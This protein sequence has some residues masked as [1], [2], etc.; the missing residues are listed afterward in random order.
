MIRWLSFDPTVRRNVRWVAILV[1]ALVVV[2]VGWLLFSVSRPGFHWINEDHYIDYQAGALLKGGHWHWTIAAVAYDFGHSNGWVLPPVY[3]VFLSMFASGEHVAE[4]PAAIAQ[5]IISSLTPLAVFWMAVRLHGPRAGLLAAALAASGQL[6]APVNAFVQE[7]IYVPLLI[8]SLAA[9]IHAIDLDS[10]P[11][12]WFAAGVLMAVTT[13]TRALTLY[14][15]P[16]AILWGWWFAADRRHA[17]AQWRAYGTG[18]LALVLP[19]IIYV[20]IATGELVLIDNHGGTLQLVDL[21]PGVA[22]PTDLVSS[23]RAVLGPLLQA[24]GAFVADFLSYVSIQFRAN[25]GTWLAS[26]GD[27]PTPALALVQKIGAHLS[28]DLPWTIAA[29]LGPIGFAF[30][31][32][33]RAAQLMVLWVIVAIGLTSL[34]HYAGPRYRVPFESTLAVA[35]CV[36]VAGPRIAP[37]R[38]MLAAGIGSSLAIAYV[39]T[40]SIVSSLETRAGYGLG[41]W[42]VV[43]DQYR[44]ADA[45]GTSGFS[46]KS[47]GRVAYVKL[48]SL[49]PSAP[50]IVDVRFGGKPYRTVDLL[51]STELLIPVPYDWR[52]W[53]VEID[54][55]SGTG[56]PVP[57]QVTTVRP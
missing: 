44:T 7:Q 19:Y 31:R 36:L 54:A 49:R 45:H 32:Q 25:G 33:R 5:L 53:F 52:G 22:P 20:S 30:A 17:F 50:S 2:R 41:P 1:A 21:N 35:A 4:L 12:V 29:V 42:A 28:I 47:V 9:L 38:W 43:S 18:F 13:L 48:E 11:R 10:R 37:R 23:M 26:T 56:E 55:R 6:F 8:A 46:V 40:P 3:P 24:P 15:V 51:G 34:A 39:M 27:M 16:L 14:F 57:Y